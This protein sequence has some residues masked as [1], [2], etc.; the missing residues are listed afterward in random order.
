MRLK[1]IE[2][3]VRYGDKKSAEFTLGAVKRRFKDWAK[4]IEEYNDL[5]PKKKKEFKKDPLN[6]AIID[7]YEEIAPFIVKLEKICSQL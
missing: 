4:I 3:I 6:C 1:D 5:P 7:E 2:D